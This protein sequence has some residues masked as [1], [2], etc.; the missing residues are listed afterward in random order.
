MSRLLQRFAYNVTQAYK[1]GTHNGIDIVGVNNGVNVCDYLL[2]HSDGKVVKAVDGLDNDK[3]NSSNYGNYV[4]IEH[5][6]G[7]ATLYAHIKKATIK[8]KEGQAV[9]QGDVIGYMGNTGYSFGAHLH[10]E[11]FENGQKID[12]TKYLDADLP[13]IAPSKFKIGDI[14]RIK[15]GATNINGVK[16]A[17]WVYNSDL[18]VRIINGAKISVSTTINGAITCT[19]YDS[20]LILVSANSTVPASPSAPTIKVG[21]IVKLK[22]DATTTSGKKFSSWVYNAKLYVRDIVGDTAAISTVPTG[23]VTGRTYITSLIK[24]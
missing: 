24:L 19:V 3:T 2:A 8:V 13:T 7:Y 18:F 17:N 4:K 6:N 9:K 22:A 1:Q 21:D 23:A 14:V 11:V 15:S 12:P 16:L 5:A 10:F 20:D